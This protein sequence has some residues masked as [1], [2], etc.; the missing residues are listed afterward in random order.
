ML[1][2]ERTPG[3]QR[4]YREED[5]DSMLNDPSHRNSAKDRAREVVPQIFSAQ[6]EGSQTAECSSPWDRRIREERADLEVIKLRRERAALVRAERQGREERE[7]EAEE[8]RSD[9]ARRATE[10]RRIAHARAEENARLDALRTYGRHLSWL[11]PTEYQAKVVRDLL[12]SVNSHEYPREMPDHLAKAQVAVRIDELLKP[13]RDSQAREREKVDHEWTRNRF[14][15][16][17]MSHGRSQTR[18]WDRDEAERAQRDIER[19]LREETDGDWTE[20]DVK[21]L[22]DD[23]LDEWEEE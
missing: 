9:S 3:G 23:I 5:I 11:A 19:S 12:K 16:A 21:D 13:W 15:A 1:D 22:V 10:S 8:R 17:G 6:I 14:I 20:D 7:R 2:S 4:R 18:K